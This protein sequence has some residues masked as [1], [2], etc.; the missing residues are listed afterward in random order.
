MMR[1]DRLDEAE[2]QLRA[3]IDADD[4][5]PPAHYRLG[6]VLEKNNG[7][8]RRSVNWSERRRWIPHIL[9]RTMHSPGSIGAI[10]ERSL[11]SE[12]IPARQ[13]AIPC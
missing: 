10:H 2:A 1:L 9:T 12:V 13:T 5:F 11:H 4:S 8:T 6:Q 3:S 7:L